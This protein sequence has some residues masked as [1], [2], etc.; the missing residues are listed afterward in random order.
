MLV[1]LASTGLEKG[2]EMACLDMIPLGWVLTKAS[3]S[4]P[5]IAEIGWAPT[6]QH[7]H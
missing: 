6:Q 4:F 7:P 2:Q 3:K 5:A 1:K